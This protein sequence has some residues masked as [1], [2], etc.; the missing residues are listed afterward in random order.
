MP[1]PAL[2]RPA[3][4]HFPRLWS[5]GAPLWNRRPEA[6]RP[7]PGHGHTHLQ[8]LPRCATSLTG[9][10][11]F[12]RVRPPKNGFSVARVY[13]DLM[14]G[15]ADDFFK[16][17]WYF[18]FCELLIHI[19]DPFSSWLSFLFGLQI[20][21]SF[22]LNVPTFSHNLSLV[23]YQQ[24]WNLCLM[25]ASVLQAGLSSLPPPASLSTY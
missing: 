15:G 14:T 24:V 25:E 9:Q 7:G 23:F 1:V 21:N 6:G 22:V 3:P 18:L 10:T 5:S 17:L 8:T 4:F 12:L 2:K 19:L 16:S 20:T 13:T 11:S